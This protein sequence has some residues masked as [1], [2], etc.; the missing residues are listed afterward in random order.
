MVPNVDTS[1]LVAVLSYFILL[2]APIIASSSIDSHRLNHRRHID[3]DADSSGLSQRSPFATRIGTKQQQQIRSK[4]WSKRWT[5]AGT[6]MGM[7]RKDEATNKKRHQHSRN[8]KDAIAGQA[9]HQMLLEHLTTSTIQADTGTSKANNDG[10]LSMDEIESGNENFV[11]DCDNNNNNNINDQ[12]DGYNQAEKDANGAASDTVSINNTDGN[13]DKD[14]DALDGDQ[15]LI[16]LLA[17]TIQDPT[18]ITAA[19]AETSASSD[20]VARR[21]AVSALA[22]NYDTPTLSGQTSANTINRPTPQLM[23]PQDST[24]TIAT[25]TTTTSSTTPRPTAVDYGTRFDQLMKEAIKWSAQFDDFV[26]RRMGEI[27]E[28]IRKLF[29]PPQ[30]RGGGALLQQF[31]HAAY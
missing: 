3:S 20:A 23:R 25:T 26:G 12:A 21:T 19:T 7:R 9:N 15:S 11:Y 5:M 18:A 17:K 6:S 10:G 1:L 8:D 29:P 27:W 22:T 28:Q 2:Y 14:D 16:A 24:T 30:P 13:S 4:E 31:S